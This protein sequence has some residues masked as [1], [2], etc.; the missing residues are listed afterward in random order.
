MPSRRRVTWAKFRVAAVCVVAAVIV[1]TLVYV[2]TGGTLLQKKATV[3]LYIPDATGLTSDSPVRVDGIA[4]GK[5]ASV[6]LSGSNKPDRVS[7]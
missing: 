3:Y 4:V 5:V 7:G 6:D 1:G 2:L